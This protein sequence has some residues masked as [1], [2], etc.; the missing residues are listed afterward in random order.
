[1]RSTI[2]V[3]NGR[4]AGCQWAADVQQDLCCSSSQQW[5]A[6]IWICQFRALSL[7]DVVFMSKTAMTVL[8]RILDSNLVASSRLCSYSHRQKSS[9]TCCCVEYTLFVCRFNTV[10]YIEHISKIALSLLSSIITVLRSLVPGNQ[11]KNKIASKDTSA[12]IAVSPLNSTTTTQEGSIENV[13]N[14]TSLITLVSEELNAVGELW[15]TKLRLIIE[16]L[17]H[18][19]NTVMSILVLMFVCKDVDVKIDTGGPN[20]T[21][22][23]ST[24][25]IRAKV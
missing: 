11:K 7:L 23:S 18:H 22:S 1:M 20:H 5:L 10:L 2:E 24:W 21:N 25:W 14:K 15:P 6:T 13:H 17:A 3:L 9:S 4:L 12:D 16:P 8:N 19:L